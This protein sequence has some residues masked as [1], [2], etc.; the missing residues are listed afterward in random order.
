ML[1]NFKITDKFNNF[2]LFAIK[3][4]HT[5]LVVQSRLYKP[6]GTEKVLINCNQQSVIKLSNVH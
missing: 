6:A 3:Q 2:S 1:L 5:H 4:S